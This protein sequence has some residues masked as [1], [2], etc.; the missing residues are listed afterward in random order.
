MGG[1]EASTIGSYNVKQ[2]RHSDMGDG[3][4]YPREE[5]ATECAMPAELQ[6]ILILI[7]SKNPGL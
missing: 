6:P 2:Q 4:L 5:P 3:M 7:P 1:E